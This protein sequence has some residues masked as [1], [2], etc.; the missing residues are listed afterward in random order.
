MNLNASKQ[1]RGLLINKLTEGWVK[2]ASCL[3]Q[4]EPDGDG[5]PF[6]LIPYRE[7][8]KAIFFTGGINCKREF[9]CN[10]CWSRNVCMKKVLNK[11]LREAKIKHRFDK[12]VNI[13]DVVSGK[14]KINTYYDAIAEAVK[15]YLFK[16]Y[17]LK[18]E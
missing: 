14:I 16:A 4:K 3:L 1:R 9:V 15:T 11:L 12:E 13:I 17:I 8:L 10:E 6:L 7:E 18:T 5:L 2:F